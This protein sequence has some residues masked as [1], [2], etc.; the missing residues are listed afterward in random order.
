MVVLFK[1]L[2]VWMLIRFMLIFFLVNF[3]VVFIVCYIMWLV[4][5]M[6]ILLFFVMCSVL[7]IL[8]GIFLVNIGYFGC[9]KWRYIGLL[10]LVI[11]MVVVLVW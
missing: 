1:G 8:N 7:L 5:K 2:M 11:V 3:L 9:L 6:D 10:C 4:V